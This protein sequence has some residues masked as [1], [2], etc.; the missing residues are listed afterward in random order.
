MSIERVTPVMVIVNSA[1]FVP[2]F[3]SMTRMSLMLTF[4]GGSS[5]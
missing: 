4:G 2:L 3:P 1:F 5:S